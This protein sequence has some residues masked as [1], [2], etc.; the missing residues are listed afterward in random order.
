MLSCPSCQF[1]HT[2]AKWH[3]K[4]QMSY[5]NLIPRQKPTKEVWGFFPNKILKGEI[6]KTSCC[7]S[8][9]LKLTIS[10]IWT[11]I[12]KQ[13]VILSLTERSKF[14]KNI[15]ESCQKTTT[16][17]WNIFSFLIHTTYFW[18]PSHKA[19]CATPLYYCF[20]LCLSSYRLDNIECK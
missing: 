4:G 10:C 14:L 12:T 3:V 15:S 5:I 16:L 20:L 13:F 8:T 18:K 19:H 7:N 9:G 1:Q 6:L 2:I 11:A 17:Q